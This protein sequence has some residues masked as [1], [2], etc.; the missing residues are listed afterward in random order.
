MTL[1]R[2]IISGVL[3]LIGLIYGIYFSVNNLDVI[4]VRVPG[5]GDHPAPV[6]VVTLC[7]FFLG[8]LI[9]ALYSSVSHVS[10][11]L[12]L[13]KLRKDLDGSRRP[14]HKRVRRFLKEDEP[15]TKAE[16]SIHS[17]DSKEF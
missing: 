4:M 8:A 13:R 16:P 7:A 10:K 11:S 9:T 5:F 15:L 1:I 12:Q 6:F 2:R 14:V 3:G 17:L